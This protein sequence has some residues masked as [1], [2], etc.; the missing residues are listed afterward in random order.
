MIIRIGFTLRSRLQFREVERQWEKR[1]VYFYW[2]MLYIFC[3]IEIWKVK[4]IVEFRGKNNNINYNQMILLRCY[5]IVL[6][7]H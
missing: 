4:F 3:N 5:E 6:S 2:V 7:Y 1:M